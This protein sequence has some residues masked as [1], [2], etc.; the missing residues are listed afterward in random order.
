MSP[1]ARHQNDEKAPPLPGEG[2]RRGRGGA[3]KISGA[4]V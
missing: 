1:T 4:R 2:Q 3:G